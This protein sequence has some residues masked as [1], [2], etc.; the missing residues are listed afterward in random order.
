MK[1]MLE[2]EFDWE[3]VKLYIDWCFGCVVCEIFCFFGVKYGELIS[4]F[5]GELFR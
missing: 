3:D 1:E 2:G 5:C 4:L